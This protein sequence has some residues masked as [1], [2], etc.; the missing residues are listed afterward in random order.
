LRLYENCARTYAGTVPEANIIKLGRGEPKISYLSYP[1]FESEPHPALAESMSVHLQTFRI[2]T[3]SYREY[4]NPPILH[5]KE[6][7]ITRDHP[8]RAK[9]ERL[10]RIEEGKGLYDEPSSIGTRAGWSQALSRK[11]LTFLGHRLVR[12]TSDNSR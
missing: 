5:R 8:L 4:L 9:F 11:G 12:T 3:R 6:E 2:R 1:G 10:T 7:F